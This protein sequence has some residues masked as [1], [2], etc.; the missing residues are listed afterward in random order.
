MY[1]LIL[2]VKQKSP[3]PFSGQTVTFWTI[4]TFS[5]FLS[6]TLCVDLNAHA[7]DFIPLL[8]KAKEILWESFPVR[9]RQSFP[10]RAPIGDQRSV[11]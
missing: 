1:N 9:S 6:F 3:T 10:S 5:C 2:P 8:Q 7:I 11:P 4:L